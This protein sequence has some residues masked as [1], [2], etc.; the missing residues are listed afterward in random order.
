MLLGYLIGILSGGFTVSFRGNMR[1]GRVVLQ[2][3]LWLDPRFFFVMRDS[4]SHV[5]TVMVLVVVA[6]AYLTNGLDKGRSGTRKLASRHEG[7]KDLWR[8]SRIRIWT[9]FIEDL[10]SI[11]RVVRSKVIRNWSTVDRTKRRRCITG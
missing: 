8:R 10:T 9:I 4:L 7:V 5:V 3:L 6:Q 11:A 1:G 2:F